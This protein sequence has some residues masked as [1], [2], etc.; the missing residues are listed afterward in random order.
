MRVFFNNIIQSEWIIYHLR[1][2]NNDEIHTQEGLQIILNKPKSYLY[3]FL[4][5]KLLRC[6]GNTINIRYFPE[7]SNMFFG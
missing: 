2:D 6:H 3:V 4:Y 7:K 5:I 1:C